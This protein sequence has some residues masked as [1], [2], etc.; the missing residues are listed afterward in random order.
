MISSGFSRNVLGFCA[1]A[2]LLAGCGG[3][4]SPV[5]SGAMPNGIAAPTYATQSS[6]PLRAQSGFAYLYTFKAYADGAVPEGPLVAMGDKLYGTTT[7]G[8]ATSRGTVFALTTSGAERVVYSFG[9]QGI[10]YED[11]AGP[12]YLIAHASVLYGS[13]YEGG[14]ANDGTAFALSASGRERFV[15]SFKARISGAMP[16]ALVAMNGMIYGIA[17]GGRFGNGLVFEITPSGKEHSLHLFKGRSDGATPESLVVVDNELYGT[18]SGGGSGARGTVF[19]IDSQGKEHI[20]YNFDGLSGSPV[21]PLLYVNGEL[22]GSTAYG[23]IFAMKTSGKERAV[24]S[25][26][27]GALLSYMSN[28][29]YAV[30]PGYVNG[31][32]YKV[33]TSGHVT[34]LHQFSAHKGGREPSSPLLPLNGVLYGATAFAARG[35]H[36]TVYQLGP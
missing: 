1:A 26:I 30:V 24:T 22:Y 15:F 13:T 14:L 29:L 3:S 18:T 23:G 2:A 31:A 21:G 20:I 6:L 27:K 33:S 10:S 17:Q 19:K 7:G 5:T 4:Q 16:S 8:G 32:I 35:G 12:W 36:G 34:K 25:G 11:G 9:D 28:A